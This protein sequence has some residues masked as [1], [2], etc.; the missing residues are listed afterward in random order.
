[1][2]IVISV[3]FKQL[4]ELL[5]KI[6]PAIDELGGSIKSIEPENSDLIKVFGSGGWIGACL[7]FDCNSIRL[8]MQ[9]LNR[10][11]I[12]ETQKI[13]DQCDKVAK[14][15][16]SFEEN[17]ELAMSELKYNPTY[18][19]EFDFEKKWQLDSINNLRKEYK[20]KKLTKPYLPAKKNP[21]F[22]FK[23]YLN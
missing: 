13:V 23:R 8:V 17:I 4:D 5:E 16:K 1:M 7:G 6:A 22:I 11:H 2:E 10:A 9:D 18:L 15:I 14:E 3:N 19:E 21:N 20:V 12:E